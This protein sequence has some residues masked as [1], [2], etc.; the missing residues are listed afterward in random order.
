M[1][2]TPIGLVLAKIEGTYGTDPTPTE[3]ANAIAVVRDSVKYDAKFTHIARKIL[4]GTFDEVSGQNVMPEVSFSLQVELRGNRT[5]G[6]TPDIS[7]GN[8]ANPV[9][10]D[11]LLQSCDLA[12]LYTLE[13]PSGTRNGYVIYSPTVPSD[14]GKSVTFYFYTG[15]KKHIVTGCK[16]TAKVDMSAGKFGTID[17]TF[18]GLFNAPSDASVPSSPVFL[19]TTPPVFENSGSTIDSFSPTFTKLDFDLGTTVSKREDANSVN[20]VAGFLITNRV[21]KLTIDP[22]SVAEA[23]DPI[24]ADLAGGVTRTITGKI[25]TLTG[26]QIQLTCKGISES[27][28]YGDRSGIRTQPISYSVERLAS[29]TPGSQIALK[30]F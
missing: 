9:E 17:F 14:Q 11:C 1:E 7:S 28:S 4:D 8:T 16:G 5:D 2:R 10:I 13:T 27:V 12:P 15:S 23:T 21:S 20:G 22:E 30:F 3:T 24:W 18:T 29:D 26:N 25:G 19:N 6:T